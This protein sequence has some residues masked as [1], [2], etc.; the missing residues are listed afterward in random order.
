MIGI[1]NYTVVLTY[2]G[3]LSGFAGITF[4]LNGIIHSA[5]I[6][7]IVAGICDV[8]DGKVASTMDRN[9]REKRFGVQIDS[10]SDL[11]SF[12]VLPAVITVS[13]CNNSTFS[14][15]MASMY[16]LAAL[17]R[18]AWFNVDEEERQDSED[19]RRKYYLGLPVTL[20]AVF[21]PITAWISEGME[22]SG[23]RVYPTLLAIL[24]AAFLAPVKIR[25]PSLPK[26]GLVICGGAGLVLL[27]MS[28][29]D[30]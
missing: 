17:I 29:M 10:L 8:F 21:V 18:L 30:M 3:M 7:L 11:I 2:I 9:Q 24:A 23:M 14:Y 28:G 16:V 13:H 20:S 4:A 15:C 27:L 25:K 19:G 22:L 5:M 12:G 1:Y 6:C 26:V